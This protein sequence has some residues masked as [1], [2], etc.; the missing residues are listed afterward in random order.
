MQIILLVS[1]PFVALIRISHSSI[2]DY[3]NFSLYALNHSR[4]L[5]LKR[6]CFSYDYKGP[7]YIYYKETEEQKIFYE[8]KMQQ[9]N[10]EEIEAEAR[11]EFNRIQAE[12]EEK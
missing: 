5:S 6:G 4:F 1:C 3:V 9:N 12:K 7:C 11:A 2:N 8:E 10:D